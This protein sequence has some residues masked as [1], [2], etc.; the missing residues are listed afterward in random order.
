[1]RDR[2]LHQQNCFRPS[3]GSLK[4]VGQINPQIQSIRESLEK[5]RAEM[6]TSFPVS[7]FFGRMNSA[8][9]PRFTGSAILKETI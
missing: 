9:Q 1:M 5:R 6:H 2:I 7:G 8:L 4:V 3:L